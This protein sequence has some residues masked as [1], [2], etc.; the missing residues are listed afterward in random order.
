MRESPPECLPRAEMLTA[1]TSI[2]LNVD[3]VNMRRNKVASRGSGRGFS[4]GS[5][6]PRHS[7]AITLVDRR[8][9]WC[10]G[11]CILV[12]GHAEPARQAAQGGPGHREA[13]QGGGPQGSE[14]AGH[15]EAE[16]AVGLRGG[17]PAARGVRPARGGAGGGTPQGGGEEGRGAATVRARPAAA[18]TGGGEPRARAAGRGELPLRQAKRQGRPAGPVARDREAPGERRGGRGGGPGKPRARRGA[19]RGG[20]ADLRGGQAGGAVL[21]RSGEA[22]R[23]RAGLVTGCA[24]GASRP[25]RGP[26]RKGRSPRV[27][28]TYTTLV[29][30]LPGRLQDEVPD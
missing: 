21:V 26:G 29:S 19:R 10:R 28:G 13:G 22:D 14:A 1:P 25:T 7:G 27:P 18:A 17:A 20:E 23:F 15:G 2:A 5:R 9:A 24:S 6:M 4:G 12:C 30:T 11:R 3:G 8:P 16:A